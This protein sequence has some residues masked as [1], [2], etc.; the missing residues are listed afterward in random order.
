MSLSVDDV[1]KIALN[2]HMISCLFNYINVNNYY[3]KVNVL[4]YQNYIIQMY[5]TVIKFD[6][7][8]IANHSYFTVQHIVH[9]ISLLKFTNLFSLLN[10]VTQNKPHSIIH[11]KCHHLSVKRIRKKSKDSFIDLYQLSTMP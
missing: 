8:Q 7:Q 6:Y 1:L 11:C 4:M 5:I 2:L 9:L 3:F 10:V